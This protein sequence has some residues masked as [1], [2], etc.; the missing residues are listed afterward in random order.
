M[1]NMPFIKQVRKIIP[2]TMVY[3]MDILFI[4]AIS[5]IN[6]TEELTI[7]TILLRL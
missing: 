1:K 7:N 3:E 6:K 4:H 5:N 2:I